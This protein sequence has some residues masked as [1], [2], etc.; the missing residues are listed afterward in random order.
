LFAKTLLVHGL[1]IRISALYVNEILIANVMFGVDA[2]HRVLPGS[3][4]CRGHFNN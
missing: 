4:V 3:T 2:S 1:T